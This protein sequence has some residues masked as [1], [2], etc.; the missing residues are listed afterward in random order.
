MRSSTF[1]NQSLVQ[2]IIDAVEWSKKNLCQAREV[3]TA[4]LLKVYGTMVTLH[5]EDDTGY[6]G[7]LSS[8]VG[9][10]LGDISREYPMTLSAFLPERE[11]FMRT[12]SDSP[13]LC[14]N[15]YSFREHSEL[16]GQTLSENGLYLQHPHSYDTSVNYSN[17]HYLDRPGM[18][19]D[20]K[21]LG[22]KNLEKPIARSKIEFGYGQS[23][24]NI[25]IHI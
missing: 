13:K 1:K 3:Q 10:V 17:P 4:V 16:I 18:P 9:Q 20:F 2:V 5:T 12:L 23:T 8:R 19:I 6:L 14:I 24:S 22:S 15:L 7:L 21:L 11:L 25:H